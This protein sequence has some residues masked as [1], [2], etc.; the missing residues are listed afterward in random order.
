MIKKYKILHV[1]G[2]LNIGGAERYLVRLTNSLDRRSF[3][4]WIVHTDG[5]LIKD[6]I[7]NDDVEIIKL[8]ERKAT[9]KNPIDW[10]NIF[11]FYKLIKILNID[12]VNTHS[13]GIF[14][15]TAWIA[16]K[17]LQ[18][19]VVHIIQHVYAVRS[20][21]EDFMIKI[22]GIRHLLYSLVDRYVALSKYMKNEFIDLW[23]IPP[24]KIYLNPLGIDLNE[25]RPSI[26]NRMKLKQELHIEPEAPI[27]GVVARL[28]P[29][30]GV[31]KAINIL[32]E[33]KKEIPNI[34]LIIVGDGPM[35]NKY[36]KLVSDLGLK[37]SVI[38]TG[39]RQDVPQLMDIFDI[40]LQTTNAPLMGNTTLEAMAVGK[41]IAIIVQN[42]AEEAMARETVIEG[43]NG[44]LIHLNHPE[45]TIKLVRL[46]KDK[47]TL[48]KMG[49]A[50]RKLAEERFD[51]HLHVK[52]MERLYSDLIWSSKK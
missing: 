23:K 20:R 22:P 28:S 21:T 15:I 2:T 17:L 25:F 31:H 37:Q 40:Y 1:I 9:A 52:N 51:L 12:L 36:E 38:F 43:Y 4:Q 16:A 45:A 3:K 39:F 44:V 11:K 26:V 47:E 27:I 29:V 50:S 34:K 49:N 5:D 48:D 32:P 30:K 13:A 41:P 19:P 18:I 24:Q 46:L 35:R 42:E 14:C 10:L 33:V 7:T 8:Q 6:Q